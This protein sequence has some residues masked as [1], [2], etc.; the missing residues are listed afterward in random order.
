[1]PAYVLVRNLSF[2]NISR[3]LIEENFLPTTCDD[4]LLLWKYVHRNV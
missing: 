1:M 2:I 3:F 4:E